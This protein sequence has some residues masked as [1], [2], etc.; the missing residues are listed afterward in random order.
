MTAA[1]VLP[2][3]RRV[4]TSIPRTSS[5]GLVHELA[6]E[7]MDEVP[8]PEEACRRGE[9]TVI[10]SLVRVLE[11][12]GQSAGC[13]KSIQ[14]DQSEYLLRFQQSRGCDDSHVFKLYG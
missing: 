10:R 4:S 3:R 12:A 11:L 13:E 5:T 8:D 7:A 9:Y 1:S 14:A 6:E 2:R